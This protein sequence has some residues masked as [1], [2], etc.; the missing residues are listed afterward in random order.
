[1]YTD[2][3]HLC[4]CTLIASNLLFFVVSKMSWSVFV[5]YAT[6]VSFL[7]SFHIPNSISYIVK[8]GETLFSCS[9]VTMGHH[10]GSPQRVV[11]CVWFDRFFCRMP[12]LT[13]PQRGFVSLARSESATFCLPNKCVIHYN[14]EPLMILY[15]R[16]NEKYGTK[17]RRWHILHT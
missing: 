12:F 15:L 14:I 1:M 10:N 4:E 9:L 7:R 6:K 3:L 11:L 2:F 13:Q 5:C 8:E 17:E 16:K